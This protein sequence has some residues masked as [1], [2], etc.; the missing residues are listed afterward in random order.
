MSLYIL[1][2]AEAR[3]ELGLTD[4][5]DDEVLARWMDGLQGRFDGFLKRT[6]ARATD[7]VEL[8]DGGEPVLYLKRWPVES[9]TSVHMDADQVWDAASLLDSGDYRLSALRGTL[10]R[11]VDGM[12]RWDKGVQNVRVVYSGGFVPAGQT[13]TA[14]QFAMPDDLRR[15]FAMQLGYEWRNRRSLGQ[16]SVAAQGVS[17]SLAPAALLPDVE[18]VLNPY[19]RMA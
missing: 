8:L 3:A 15:A 19:R 11:G 5:A 16:Q 18:A 2:L 6:L 4:T 12:I 14:A 1:T 10:V 7:A 9:V 17:V 13:A